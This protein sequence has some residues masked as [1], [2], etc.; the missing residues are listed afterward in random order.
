[1]DGVVYSHKKENCVIPE[2][3]QCH[4]AY[5]EPLFFNYF[6][7]GFFFFFFFF[8]IFPKAEEVEKRGES[9]GAGVADL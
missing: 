2:H 8:S 3:M 4:Y 1:M 6:F 7:L 5:K 9:I